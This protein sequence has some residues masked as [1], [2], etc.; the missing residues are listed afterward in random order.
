MNLKNHSGFV[1][2]EALIAVG[3][4]ILF[5]GSL[6][7][8][9]LLNLRGTA[10]INNSNQAE[11]LARSGLDALRTID[12]DDLNLI[13]SGHLVFFGASWTVVAGS[14]VTDV[15]TKTVRVREVQRDVDCEIVAV[16]GV[17]DE[18]SKFIDS[19]V[20]WTD[21][22][23]RVHQTFLTSLITRWDNPQGLCF[24]PSAAANL[25][26]HTE[27][28]LWYGGKQLRELYLENGGS[29]PFTVNYLTFTW[30]NGASIQQIFLDS[31]K[32]WSSS[33]PG[34]P[35]GTQV[36]GTRLDIFDYTFDPGEILDMNKTQ[37][38]TPMAGTTLT[39]TIEFTDGSIFVSD[40]FTPL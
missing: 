18:D 24:A 8:L 4:L 14:E 30:D 33:G 1:L 22:L 36:S 37:F 21:D 34:L 5:L 2:L 20:S 39:L 31:T 29:V 7:T 27:T 28:T 15:F 38:D 16:G 6:G 35:I 12:F 32:I 11:L 9:F 17:L 26:F 23:G 19:E 13:N 10:L 40:P 3:L 25:I